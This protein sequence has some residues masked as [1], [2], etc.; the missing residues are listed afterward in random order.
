MS[1]RD[2][3]NEIE[4]KKLRASGYFDAA[5]KLSLLRITFNRQ[6]K[7]L[8]KTDASW[9]L[10][11]VGIV[12]CIELAVREAICKLIDHG[13]PYID[14]IGEFKDVLKLDVSI[15]RALQD[16]RISFGD[17]LS[18]LLPV[19][20]IEQINSHFGALFQKDFRQVLADA[21]EF[22]EP[23]MS[24]ILE[25]DEQEEV[26]AL[27]Q[28]QDREGGETPLLPISDVP[29]LIA[30]LGRLFKARHN[31]AHEADFDSVTANDVQGFFR[32]AE[33]FIHALDET[34]WQII[35]PRMPRTAF[36]MSLVISK[37]ASKVQDEMEEVEA[38]LFSLLSDNVKTPVAL[39]PNGGES[40]LKAFKKARKAFKKYLDAEVTFD[41]VRVGMISGNG[42]RILEAETLKDFCEFRI[43]RLKKA[44]EY[45]EY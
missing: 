40:E 1:K 28:Q 4:A 14:R 9:A 6:E 20:N 30:S 8:T 2:L 44:M 22:V 19:S 10:F 41:L 23:S 5:H 15:A 37:E 21:R 3:L 25:D 36:G 24:E 45:F 12:A 42:L 34:V 38:K 18:H 43:K 26:Q 7:V 35:E 27:E 17:L 31:V 11:I 13:S 39:K 16:T 33:V 29:A 32:T